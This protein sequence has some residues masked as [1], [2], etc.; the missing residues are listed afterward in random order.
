MS[1]LLLIAIFLTLASALACS[2]GTPEATPA[3][4]GVEPAMSAPVEP[5]TLAPTATL[6]PVRRSTPTPISTA[7]PP[8]TPAAT[9]ADSGSSAITPLNAES[10]Q[11][12]LAELSADE[13]SCISETI[14]AQELEALVQ[15]LDSLSPSPPP[16]EATALVECLEDGAL[17]RLFSTGVTEQTGPLSAETGTCLRGGLA[18]FDLG[19]IM[20]AGLVESD[21]EAAMMG[22]MAA[23]LVMLSCL[24]EEEWEAASPALEL[25][26]EDRE[27]VRCVMEE[28][29]GPDG[30]AEALQP[31]AD[32]GPPLAFF[33]AAMGCQL[34]QVVEGPPP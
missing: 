18:G 22:S 16:A 21:D 7:T 8:P 31:T 12:F 5:P 2:R 32:S 29:G 33:Q 28:L 6:V 19:A 3:A 14:G 4:T 34:Q 13:Q 20:L 23:F 11:T 25:R 10:P 24:N 17:L 15:S 9:E 27:G 1:K 26:P 30:V